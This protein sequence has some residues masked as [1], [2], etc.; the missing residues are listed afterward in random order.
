MSECKFYVYAY[1]RQKS[2]KI[3]ESGTPYYI[4]KGSNSRAYTNHSNLPIPK[5]RY[6][7]R[8]IESGLSEIGAFALERRL[9]RWYGRIDLH[10]GILRNKTDGGDGATGRSGKLSPRYGIPRPDVAARNKLSSGDNHPSRKL[11]YVHPMKGKQHS[12]ETLEKFKER[13][14]NFVHPNKGKHL[15]EETRRKISEGN[16]GKTCIAWNKGIKMPEEYS[17]KLSEE[18]QR[19]KWWTN[20]ETGQMKQC[21]IDLGEGWVRGRKGKWNT[22]GS[23]NFHV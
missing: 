21:T 12:T 10:S 20:I 13:S 16:K 3:A 2:S 5:D 22:P 15:S 19:R 18:R 11:G 14:K 6:F 8:I 1:I 7:I 17:L 23:K 9:I 4:G